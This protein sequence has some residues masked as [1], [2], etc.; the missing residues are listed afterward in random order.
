VNTVVPG[1]LIVIVLAWMVVDA[2]KR[3]KSARIRQSP[4]TMNLDDF[5]CAFEVLYRLS[6]ATCG[7][8]DFGWRKVMSAKRHLDQRFEEFMRP[9]V[10]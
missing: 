4:E 7:R 5:E 10:K 2:L 1:E 3:P 8:N 6:L 9:T